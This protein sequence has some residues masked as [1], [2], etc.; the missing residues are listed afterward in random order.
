MSRI[1]SAGTWVSKNYSSCSLNHEM[2]QTIDNIKRIRVQSRLTSTTLKCDVG[3]TNGPLRAKVQ[4]GSW[5]EG[6]TMRVEI[7]VH[8]IPTKL[9]EAFSRWPVLVGHKLYNELFFEC[10]L[11]SYCV[12]GFINFSPAIILS[13][14]Y[15]I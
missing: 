13:N 5:A 4:N 7:F 15:P 6:G 14:N 3:S 10:F 9:G 11:S 12:S 8:P 1:L 2:I